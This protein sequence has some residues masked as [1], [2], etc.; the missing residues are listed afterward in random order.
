MSR[1]SFLAA[2]ATA[3]LGQTACR[4]DARGRPRLAVGDDDG[5]EAGRLTARPDPNVRSAVEPGERHLGLADRRDALVYV[6]TSYRPGRPAPLAVELHGAGGKAKGGLRLWYREADA[7]GIV[8]VAPPSRDVTWDV[9]LG[10][11]GPDVE[12]IDR[13]L[14]V[15]FGEVAVDPERVAINGFSDGAS[16]A[17]SLGLTN[18]DLFTNIAAF[19]PG[20][21]RSGDRVGKPRI[22]EA[23]GTK[24]RTLP[25]DRTSRRIVPDLR[26]EGYDVTY[27]EFAGEHHVEPDIT[28]RAARWFVD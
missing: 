19:S 7:L 5:H 16:Y 8:L 27:V 11:F 9:V 2:T 1:R 10:G 24:D 4:I 12:F 21:V 13:A 23:H 22:F 26:R 25:I 15:V 14:R 28:A 6:P 3:A 18:G 17:L 20:F